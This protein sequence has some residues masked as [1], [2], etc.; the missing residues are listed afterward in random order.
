M[1]HATEPTFAATRNACKL[2]SPL[3]ACMVF[4][5]IE[6]A[7]PLLH[8]SQGCSTYIRRYV[9]SHFKEPVDIASSNFS[10]SSAVFGGAE[11]LRAAIQNVTKQYSPSMIGIA[12]TCLS[13]TIGEDLPMML[14]QLKK[15]SPADG[16]Q[17]PDARGPAL[18]HVSTPSYS[19]THMDGFHGAVRAVADSLAQGG[20][21]THSIN[22]FP[23][24]VSVA[25]LRYLKEILGDWDIP[26][27]ILPDYSDTLNEPS[28]AEYQP[29]ARGGTPL[30]RLREMGRARA[31]IEFGRT[32]G[33]DQS[34]GTLLEDRF[35]VTNHRLGLPIGVHETD[36]LFA[37]L[38]QITGRPAPA[39]HSLERG[40]LIDSYV[41]GHKYVFGKR[42]IVYG[43]EDL[44]V[45]IVA[46]LA[47][48]GVIPVLC[49]S[50][51][52]SG[53]LRRAIDEVTRDIAS[54]IQVHQGT[55]FA[56]I[57]DACK[58]L[59]PDFLIGSSKGYSITRSLGVPLV[60]VGFP[61][62]DRLD[63]HRILHLGYRGAQ[64]LFDRITNALMEHKQE[65]APVGY[66]YM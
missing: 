35:G 14:R 18:V 42:A 11:N 2:C 19:G 46:F 64:Q 1:V 7:M 33:P 52:E 44:V 26:H 43:E 55:D 57:G 66:S 22:L 60:R 50:G 40:R 20:V 10:E 5:G 38:N 41:I 48:I 4:R 47:E 36:R 31:S 28:W 27:A 56:E 13:E 3:G 59:A 49:A 65:H 34:A 45:G 62:H 25:D 12:T 51:G 16:A 9:I 58:D 39:S 63:G 37:V 32:L 54:K 15:G 23:G 6:G 53:R 61:I 30:H 17:G 24:F 8:G 29:L 21:K